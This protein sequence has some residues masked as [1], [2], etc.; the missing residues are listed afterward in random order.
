[1]A[2]RFTL[3]SIYLRLF[4]LDHFFPKA[5]DAN[6]IAD[7]D[8]KINRPCWKN[9]TAKEKYCVFHS[10]IYINLKKSMFLLLFKTSGNT[11]LCCLPQSFKSSGIFILNT[12]F[13]IMTSVI[14]RPSGFYEN[15]WQLKILGSTPLGIEIRLDRRKP[16][17]TSRIPP[18]NKKVQKG[19]GN[20]E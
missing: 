18:S 6:K 11:L 20:K 16:F 10:G 5:L 13:W 12:S 2:L 4:L 3:N 9:V 14:A 19:F 15:L 7:F 8:H 1:M 17:L